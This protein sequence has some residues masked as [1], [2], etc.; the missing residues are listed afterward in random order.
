MGLTHFKTIVGSDEQSTGH[1]EGAA[2]PGKVIDTPN[3]P[4]LGA[5]NDH[6]LN[7]KVVTLFQSQNNGSW[8]D[9]HRGI[10]T[11][12]RTDALKWLLAHHRDQLN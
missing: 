4:S 12:V 9:I 10:H 11:I 2:V 5:D 8:K 7:D 6:P 3:G 1:Y